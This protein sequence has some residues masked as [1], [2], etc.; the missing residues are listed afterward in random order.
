MVKYILGDIR[1]GEFFDRSEEKEKMPDFTTHY[2]TA[3]KFLD[4]KGFS[5]NFCEGFYFGVQGPDLFFY[6]TPIKSGSGGYLVGG[7]LHKK[8]QKEIFAKNADRIFERN[9][10]YRGYYFGVLL[11]YFGDANVHPY[12]GFLERETKNALSHAEIEKQID[13][14]LYKKEFGE[15]VNTFKVDDYYKISSELAREI[16]AFWGERAEI[17]NLTERYVKKC[18][19]NIVN[20]NAMFTK[21]NPALL[22]FLQKIEGESKTFSGHFKFGEYDKI[23]DLEKRAWESPDGERT[24]SVPEM[25]ENA[26]KEFEAEYKKIKDGDF[27]FSDERTFEYGL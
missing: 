20:F 25:A 8:T 13:I 17:L 5:K 21:C 26:V 9:D 1:F 7:K 6:H 16:V 24:L 19:R 14:E 10:H 11:H 15:S 2:I 22:K 18:M 12:V 27:S 4:G 23:L 3:K